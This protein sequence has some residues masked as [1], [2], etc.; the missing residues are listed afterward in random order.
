MHPWLDKM[1][2]MPG[3]NWP[4]A[5]ERAIGISDFFIPCFSRRSVQ[6]KGQFQSELRYAL[7][8]ATRLPLD[9]IYI[10]P[11]RLEECHVPTRIKEHLQYVDLFP[12]WNGGVRR[13]LGA[14]RK[15]ANRSRREDLLLAG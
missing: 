5:I 13:V 12:D 9:D 6:K 3:Q 15:Q 2:L 10:I 1:K 11:V 7:E 14:I 8:C 4:R